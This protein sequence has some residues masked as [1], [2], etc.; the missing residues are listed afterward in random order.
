MQQFRF[1]CQPGCTK[2][3]EGEGQVRPTESDIENMSRYLGM[4]V[5]DFRD[6]YVTGQ[7]V[8]ATDEGRCPFLL[9]DGCSIH[10]AKPTQCRLFPFWPETVETRQAWHRTV[11]L[12]PGIGKG[13]LI[14]IERAVEIANEMKAA[15]PD[16]YR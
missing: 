3:C 8:R 14:Q 16:C 7:F 13:D 12:C 2:C 4:T 15:F 5:P 1:Q 6:R 11:Q 10:A 9:T